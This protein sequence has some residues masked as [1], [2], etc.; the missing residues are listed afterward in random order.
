MCDCG[1]GRD[2]VDVDSEDAVGIVERIKDSE[3]ANLHMLYTHGGHSYDVEY[4]DVDAII[5]TSEQERD[6]IVKFA[7]KLYG[8]W[9]AE[10]GKLIT[11]VG[12]TPR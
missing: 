5:Q 1:Y 8:M 3:F 12:S 10:E 2:G 4:G 6:T 9:L 11:G 7:N